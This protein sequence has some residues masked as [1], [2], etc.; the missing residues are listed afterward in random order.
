ML[1][2]GYYIGSKNLLTISDIIH[3][4]NKR[5]RLTVYLP[6]KESGQEISD[7]EVLPKHT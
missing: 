6:K 2:I 1:L 4:Y 7:A 3:C 5:Q